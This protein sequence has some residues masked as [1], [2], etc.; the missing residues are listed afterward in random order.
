M[1]REALAAVAR[2]E[3][4]GGI[5]GR[6]PLAKD[7]VKRV[8]G[9]E[10]V[11]SALEVASGLADRG[12]FVS[13]ERAA[14]PL[15][16]D[17]AADGVAREYRSLVD[18]I[19]AAGLAGVCEV[20]VL[21]EALGLVPGLDPDAARARFTRI[22]EHAAERSVALM[23]G[24]GPATDTT[25]SLAWADVADAEGLGVG[26]T[27]PAALRRT[28]A[29]C[30]RL[31]GRRV[32]VVKGVRGGDPSVAFGQPIEI[33]KAF[34]RCAKALLRGEGDASF[35]THDPRLL[36]IVQSLVGRYG[37]PRQSYEF[38]FFMGRLEGAQDR[39]LA[40][41]ERVRVY[42]PYGPDWFER[43]VAGLAEQPSTVTAAL[44]SMLPG[45][46]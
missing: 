12:L 25:Q 11:D 19:A 13:L 30:A 21:P 6:A 42:V 34:V 14:P 20:T 27:L 39:L 26:V 33:D 24:M 17:D 29:D 2:N 1:I 15:P 32:R 45:S 16:D 28:E 31:A 22:A 38:V 36:D 23:L 18:S 9:G 4:I 43:L 10:T 8:V 5:L 37:R 44:R 35:A 3:S 46:D 7:V 40:E 41:S